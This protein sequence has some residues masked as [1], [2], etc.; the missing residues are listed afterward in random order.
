LIARSRALSVVQSIQATAGSAAVSLLSDDARE[1]IGRLIDAEH[2]GAD[3]AHQ[4]GLVR[5]RHI[6]IP[7]HQSR[8]ILPRRQDQR[9]RQQRAEERVVAGEPVLRLRRHQDGAIRAECCEGGAGGGQA[10]GVFGGGD[11]EV[12]HGRG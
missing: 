2:I 6:G 1:R 9:L 12:G 8:R 3:V 10:R 11:W 7:D 5:D 4:R